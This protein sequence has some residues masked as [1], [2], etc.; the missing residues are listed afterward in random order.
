MTTNG[1]LLCIHQDPGQLSLLQE[2]GYELVIAPNGD[3]GLRLLESHSVDAIVLEHRS[4]LTGDGCVAAE[5][6]KIKPKVPIVI[7]AEDLHLPDEAWKS[8]DAVVAKS[9]GPHFLLATI[10]FVLNVKPA[11]RDEAEMRIR[12]RR[13]GR[14]RSGRRGAER[15]QSEVRIKNTPCPPVV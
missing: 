5:I 3:S 12:N 9:D 11:Q 15:T 6:K 14:P 13:S 4:G 7:I 10:H 1:I 8:L 2:H